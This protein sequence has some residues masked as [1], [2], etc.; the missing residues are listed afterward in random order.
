MRNLALGLSSL[1]ALVFLAFTLQ[2]SGSPV[3]QEFLPSPGKI[4]H[5]KNVLEEYP[6]KDYP[7]RIQIAESWLEF[8][9]K[10][11]VLR[12][13]SLTVDKNGD[14]IFSSKRNGNVEVLTD[15]RTG[16]TE[17]IVHTAEPN[18]GNFIP[19]IEA[20]LKAGTVSNK[21]LI[22]LN[23]NKLIL[24]ETRTDFDPDEPSHALFYG[25]LYEPKG[26]YL[27][28]QSYV[29]PKTGNL[30]ESR[31]YIVSGE[32]KILTLRH[33]TEVEDRKSVV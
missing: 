14:K 12:G 29:E 30:I 32:T 17:E 22:E 8:D 10:G 15:Y 6:G 7:P 23:G 5:V 19:R 1:L 21:G 9:S 18:K 26:S 25:H 20:G 33:S 16:R 13:K 4:W 24:Y 2:A 11:N 31:N 27:L 3:L 28:A